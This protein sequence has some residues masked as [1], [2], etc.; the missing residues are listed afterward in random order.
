MIWAGCASPPPNSSDFLFVQTGR[1]TLLWP[2]T[3][4]V[5]VTGPRTAN[6]ELPDQLGAWVQWSPDGQW[7]IY[8]RIPNGRVE[9][10]DLYLARSDGSTTQRITTGEV[11]AAHPTWSPDGNWIAYHSDEEGGLVILRIDCY[12]Y[13]KPCEEGPH[14]IASGAVYSPDWSPDGTQFVFERDGRILIVSAAGG[15]DVRDITPRLNSSFCQNPQW[16]PDGLSVAVNCYDLKRH[17]IIVVGADGTGPKNLT[18]S[19][20]GWCMHPKWSPDGEQLAVA[21]RYVDG[22]G[23]QLGLGD[24]ATGT[25][26]VYLL[27]RDGT[28]RARVT[29]REDEQ[30]FW[31][32]WIVP[33]TTAAE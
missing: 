17:N 28:S 29:F 21:C 7:V 13:G 24:S 19:F 23:E 12:F 5:D 18:E 9:Q 2:T 15:E 25:S 3:Y 32:T 26:A 20:E 27:S 6:I 22:L 1:G 8:S 31:L 4:V 16:S 33:K 14:L 10:G 30:V 11:G